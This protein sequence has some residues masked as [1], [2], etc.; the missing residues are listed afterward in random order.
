MYDWPSCILFIY[1]RNMTPQIF[2][3]PS[4]GSYT[5]EAQHFLKQFGISQEA[6]S[7]GHLAQIA[8][9]FSQFPYENISKIIKYSMRREITFRMPDEIYEDFCRFRLGGTY[10]LLTYFLLEILQY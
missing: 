8:Q 3:T 2:T 5:R 4:R 1:S 6:T 7:L 10:F 9:Q